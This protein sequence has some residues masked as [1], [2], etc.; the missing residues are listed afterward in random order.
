MVTKQRKSSKVLTP[1]E[2]RKS[3]RNYF[4]YSKFSSKFLVIPGMSR[5]ARDFSSEELRFSSF[6]RQ[7]GTVPDNRNVSQ[8]VLRISEEKKN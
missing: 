6:W 5:N 3:G 7:T 2:T 4:L 8:A 1:R